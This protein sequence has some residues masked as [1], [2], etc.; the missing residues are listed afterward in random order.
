MHTKLCYLLV[1]QLQKQKQVNLPNACKARSCLNKQ[2]FPV[3]GPQVH[4]VVAQLQSSVNNPA[5]DEAGSNHN[6][7]DARS[8]LFGGFR[9]DTW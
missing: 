3:K 5:G 4:V 8:S 2:C 9:D 7:K 6:G 1:D